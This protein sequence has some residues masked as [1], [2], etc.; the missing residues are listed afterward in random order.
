MNT[1]FNTLGI[2]GYGKFGKLLIELFTK[3][4]PHLKIQVYSRSHEI[5]EKVFFDQKTVFNSDIIIPCVPIRNFA[6]TIELLVPHLN[7]GQTILEICSVKLYP[8]AILEKKVPSNINLI[9]AHHMFGPATY[10]KLK[11][12]LLNCNLTIENIHCDNKIYHEIINLFKTWNL[13]VKELSADEHDRCAAEFQF[14]TLFTASVLKQLNL[15]RELIET[16][17]ALKM[18]DFLDM[19]SVDN[20]LVLD[21]YKFNPY[22]QEQFSRIVMAFNSIQNAIRNVQ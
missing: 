1:S 21:L 18:L 12:R 3:F 9:G 14:T 4:Q 11:G 13:N 2:I 17:S 8:K 16:Q 5:D 15:K 7:T 22:C 6:E 10:Q 20:D 19:I